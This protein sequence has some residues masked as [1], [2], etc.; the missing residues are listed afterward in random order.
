[1]VAVIGVVDEQK[2]LATEVA[3]HELDRLPI[4]RFAKVAAAMVISSRHQRDAATKLFEAEILFCKTANISSS[5]K[6]LRSIYSY[7]G[8]DVK[9]QGVCTLYI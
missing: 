3:A 5:V 2:A 7:L 8:T 6:T 4:R 9:R 1:M